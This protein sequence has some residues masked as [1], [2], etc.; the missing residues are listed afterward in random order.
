MLPQ[1]AGVLSCQSASERAFQHANPITPP[2]DTLSVTWCAPGKEARN[3]CCGHA[4]T[5]LSSAAFHHHPPSLARSSSQLTS[6]H[7]LNKSS[8]WPPQDLCTC[9]LTAWNVLPYRA[10]PPHPASPAF[11]SQI[12]HDYLE[13]RFD[14]SSLVGV[15]H[16]LSSVCTPCRSV[17]ACAGPWLARVPSLGGQGP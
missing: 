9:R 1:R 7:S 10:P 3:A 15:F 2:S 12:K 13:T 8:S 16:L 4:V 11:R 17:S 14:P 6:F 5:S